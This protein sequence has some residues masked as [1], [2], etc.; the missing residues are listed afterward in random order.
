MKLKYLFLSLIATAFLS[1]YIPDNDTLEIGSKAP[2]IELTSENPK[3]GEV[4]SEGYRLV[5]FWSPKNPSSRIANSEYVKYFKNHPD[6]DIAFI[7]ISTDEDDNLSAQV[8]NH[9]GVSSLGS[10]LLYSDVNER[11]FKDY[12]VENHPRAFLIG[13]DGKIKSLSPKIDDLTI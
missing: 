3:T 1:S 2:A 4:T 5:S 10:H 6:S 12:D 7:S 9:D 11:L 8:L 13:P